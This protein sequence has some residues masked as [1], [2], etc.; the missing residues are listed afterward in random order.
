MGDGHIRK[1]VHRFVGL[2]N[3]PRYY[4]IVPGM[5]EHEVAYWASMNVGVID[6]RFGEFMKALD[7]AVE[8]LFRSLSVAAD[9]KE[10]PIRR[11]YRVNSFETPQ[12]KTALGRDFT[13]LY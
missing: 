1:L 2:G 10:L 5:A 11:L 7:S 12:L 8:P 6:A 3:R 9:V 4:L 13:F